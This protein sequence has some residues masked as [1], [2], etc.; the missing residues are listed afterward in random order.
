M[1]WQSY[2][3]RNYQPILF[4][5]VFLCFEADARRR[6]SYCST[7]ARDSFWHRNA[8]PGGVLSGGLAAAGQHVFWK[9]IKHSYSWPPAILTHKQRPC[10]EE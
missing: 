8:C 1:V 4:P 9:L 7:M 2:A 5:A 10:G 6:L 3:G